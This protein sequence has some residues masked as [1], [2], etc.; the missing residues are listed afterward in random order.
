MSLQEFMEMCFYKE[1][2]YIKYVDENNNELTYNKWF[3]N[4]KILNFEELLDGG[5]KIKLFVCNSMPNGWKIRKGAMT[6]PNGFCW[7]YNGKSVFSDDYNRALL[8]LA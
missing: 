6:A 8:K 7:I 4:V 3:K 2:K 5:L 1:A